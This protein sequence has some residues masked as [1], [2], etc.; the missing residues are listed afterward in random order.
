MCRINVIQL[1]PVGDY[2]ERDAEPQRSYKER[3]A[4]PYLAFGE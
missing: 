4:E 1:D 3:D 2:K